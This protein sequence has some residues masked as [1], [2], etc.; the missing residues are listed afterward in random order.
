M[1][2]EEEAR[3]GTWREDILEVYWRLIQ[4]LDYLV[5]DESSSSWTEFVRE[6]RESKQSERTEWENIGTEWENRERVNREREQ[7]E[8]T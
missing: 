4:S 2:L 7:S 5:N 6:Q 3:I 8:R 1:E